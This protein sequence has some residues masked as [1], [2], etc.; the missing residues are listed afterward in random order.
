MN[1]FN[2]RG[3]SIVADTD[4]SREEMQGLIETAR[5]LKLKL[6]RGEPHAY[7]AGKTLAMI[8]QKP[9]TRTRVAFEVGMTQ[10]GGH[11]LYLSSTD[12]QLNRGETIEDTARVLSRYVDAI[13]AR[14]YAHA[15][16]AG[17]AGAASV[18]VYNGLSDQYHPT[19]ALADLLTL[20]EKLGPLAGRTLAYVG[21][22]N[23]MLHSLLLCGATM[24]MHL[25]V[26]TPP[27]YGP[28]AEVVALARG[29][30]VTSGSEILLTD[31]PG[32]AARGADAVYTD[33]V[34]SMGEADG[35]ERRVALHPYQVTGA[36]MAKAGPRAIF[37][38]CLPMH[39]GEE[40][41][42]EVA[43]GPQ[44]V[45]FDQA[46]NRLHMHKAILAVTLRG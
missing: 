27:A 11:A 25:R 42:A 41:T 20:T 18:P 32:E 36:L 40:A 15:D 35:P 1:G 34:A 29:L 23:N 5:D 4:L 3:R 31:D 17:L 7:L 14:V 46:E 12:L 28:S 10:L 21:A 2:L 45:I 6:R 37:M 44:S 33:V 13:M 16:V 9:S 39:R 26:A 19:Q 43:D 22:G 8:F 38:H 30:A 24:G